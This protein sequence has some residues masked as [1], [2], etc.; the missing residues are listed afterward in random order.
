MVSTQVLTPILLGLPFQPSAGPSSSAPC[1][2]Q[3]LTCLLL[4]D[5]ILSSRLGPLCCLPV[6]FQNI[7]ASSS[8]FDSLVS[9]LFIPLK[10]FVFL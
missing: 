2:F 9:Y 5:T 4:P 10:M 6:D 7:V 3:L 8:A 1:P